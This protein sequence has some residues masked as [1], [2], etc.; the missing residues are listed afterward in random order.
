M[1]NIQKKPA[2]VNEHRL[3]VVDD[4]IDICNMLRDVGEACGYEVMTTTDVTVFQ[5]L[6]QQFKPTFIMLDLSIGERDGVELLRFLSSSECKS[7]IILMSAHDERVRGSVFRL[8]KEY[9]LNMWA[10]FQ[11]PVDI[12]VIMDVLKKNT[13]KKSYVNKE[14]IIDA[15]KGNEFVVYYQ[16]IASL[17]TKKVLGVE[18][19]VRWNPKDHPIIPPDEFIVFTEELGLI[20][21]LTTLIIEQ[22][23]KQSVIWDKKE[24][25]LNIHINLSATL[26]NN[27]ELPDEIV[28]LAKKHNVTNSRICFEV[29]ETGVMSQPHIA[30]DILTRLRVKGFSLSLDD[31]GIGYSSLIELY[32]MP[33][34]EIKIDKSF[35]LKLE[36]DPE[37]HSII[38]AVIGLGHSLK[39]EVVAEGVETQEVWNKLGAMGCDIAQGYY[40]SRP[41]PP[42]DFENWLQTST[43]KELV[44][45]Q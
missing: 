7:K 27:L 45:K 1:E 17:K 24:I 6:Y 29:T 28:A 32:R 31:F 20:K 40:L 19:L 30:T 23:F 2:I 12:D 34:R 35:S 16:P 39:M 43:N 18:A 9:E 11:K 36:G 3:L 44:L 22:V 26:L 25:P 33:F 8:G 4:E 38:N 21:S 13:V 42:Q 37:C 10:H 14:R 5:N 15:I 41:L